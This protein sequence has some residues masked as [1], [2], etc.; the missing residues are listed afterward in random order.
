MQVRNV[1]RPIPWERQKKNTS[2][3]VLQLTCCPMRTLQKFCDPLKAF[4][5]DVPLISS[6]EE[7]W[8]SQ[9]LALRA[10]FF[11]SSLSTAEGIGFEYGT[12]G[13]ENDTPKKSWCRE[14][15]K[16]WNY[17]RQRISW[18]QEGSCKVCL[19]IQNRKDLMNLIA[20]L[21]DGLH[22]LILK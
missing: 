5:F 2:L 19:G 8:G 9:A 17:A 18:P 20:G 1:M 15:V 12:C 11:K 14:S 10:P 21:M 16:L 7:R 3:P 4:A 6:A 22:I 13:S